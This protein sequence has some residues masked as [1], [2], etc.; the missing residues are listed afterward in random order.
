[1][2]PT[3]APSGNGSLP[4]RYALIAMSFPRTARISLRVPASWA[5]ETT[6]QSRYPGGMLVTKIE[7][8]SWLVVFAPVALPIMPPGLSLGWGLAFCARA[9][10][11]A[12]T[13]AIARAEEIIRIAKKSFVFIF[14]PALFRFLNDCF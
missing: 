11:F 9:F 5:T 13:A 2:R 12:T 7:Y 1:M 10:W 6:F 14:L 8:H 4:S 3:I